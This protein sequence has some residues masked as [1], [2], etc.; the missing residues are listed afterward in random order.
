MITPND[1]VQ[2]PISADAF[3]DVVANA[4]NVS[5]NI[6]DRVDL[7]ARDEL[8]RFINVLLGEVAERMVTD[9]LHSC[10]KFA[11][12]SVDKTSGKPDAGHDILIRGLDGRSLTCSVK[13]SLSYKL[14]IRGILDNFK[15]ATK[16][17]EIRDVNIQVYFWLSLNPPRHEPRITIPTIRQSAIIGW[18][19]RN[20]LQEFSTYK[21]EERQAPNTML[22]EARSLHDLLGRLL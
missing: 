17:S 3:T 9:W 10:G 16:Q 20:D 7:H 19:G 22:K 8:E 18:F 15:L 1:V 4:Q 21:H 12:S 2:F 13:S 6:V 14:D 5:R 11:Q